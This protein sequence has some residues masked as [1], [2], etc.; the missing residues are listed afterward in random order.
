MA[1]LPVGLMI[2]GRMF[3]DEVVLRF[4][5]AFEQATPWHRRRPPIA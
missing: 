1:G 4:A 2:S 5:H 3:E